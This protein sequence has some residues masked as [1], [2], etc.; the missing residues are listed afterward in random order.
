MSFCV[1][2]KLTQHCKATLT[3]LPS[4]P[5]NTQ[6]LYTENDICASV[7]WK[8]KKWL[9]IRKKKLVFSPKSGSVNQS[10]Y[11]LTPSDSVC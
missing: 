2:Q 7:I 3:T 8:K 5:R 10:C 1:Q 9:R 4:A 11:P 6:D